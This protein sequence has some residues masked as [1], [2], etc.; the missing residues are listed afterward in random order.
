M[1]FLYTSHIVDGDM[2]NRTVIIDSEGYIYTRTNDIIIGDK[3]YP[4]FERI[5]E[6]SNAILQIIKNMEHKD[7]SPFYYGAVK[8]DYTPG[9]LKP[10]STIILS[11]EIKTSYNLF[12][13]L[14]P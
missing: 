13:Y 10:V 6:T 1:S 2:S 11:D 12:I 4:A 14:N 3:K 9:Y 8:F 7:K 5:G